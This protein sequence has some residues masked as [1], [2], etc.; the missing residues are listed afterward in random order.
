[1]TINKL[2]NLIEYTSSLMGVSNYLDPGILSAVMI[3]V[4]G[5]IVS[6]AMTLKLYWYKIKQKISRN[7]NS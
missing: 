5:G 3:A 1:M 6:V 7:K 4:L 2:D